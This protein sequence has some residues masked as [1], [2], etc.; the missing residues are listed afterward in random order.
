MKKLS[1]YERNAIIAEAAITYLFAR[2]T[3]L[4][5]NE[6][7]TIV[8]T[9]NRLLRPSPEFTAWEFEQAVS[10]LGEFILEEIPHV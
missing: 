9:I 7:A 6:K 3:E 8:A 4:S 5:E 10:K 2:S 1:T